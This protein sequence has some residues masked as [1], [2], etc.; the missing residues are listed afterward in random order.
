MLRGIYPRAD[1]R[2]AE[3][4]A[5]GS[6]EAGEVVEVAA[7]RGVSLLDRGDIDAAIAVF[8]H[9]FNAD[10]GREHGF[11]PIMLTHAGRASLL[12]R[13]F[14]AARGHLDQAL[15]IAQTR[16]WAGVTA[17]PL[18]LLG[19]VAVATG[20][21]VTARDL[22]EEAL[23]RACQA[24]DPCWETWAAHGLG[25][26][27]ATAGDLSAALQYLADAVT[28]SRPAR[29]GHLWSHVWALTDAA[30]LGRRLD[31]PRHV[32]W[33]DEALATAQ[34]CGMLALTSRLLQVPAITN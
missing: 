3:A 21:L 22:L 17:A 23:A 34:R 25:L 11:L 15:Q 6:G 5:L 29:G 16:S 4:E 31:D 24:A 27:A 8:R 26:H 13:D 32:A 14:S 12:A 33:Q 20:D 7:I 9:G 10:P 1:R 30:R 28:R 18:A 19:H 2:L